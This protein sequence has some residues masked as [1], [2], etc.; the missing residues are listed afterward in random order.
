MPSITTQQ[1]VTVMVPLGGMLTV[2]GSGVGRI[3][4]LRQPNGSGDPYSPVAYTG[5][6]Q[7][8]GP[9]PE[10]RMYRIV[11]DLGPIN[12]NVPPVIV[13]AENRYEPT[14]T[15]SL[16]IGSTTINVPAGS[17]LTIAAYA[18]GAGVLYQLFNNAQPGPAIAYNGSELV[19]PATN[20]LR[21]YRVVCS[22]GM[23][24]M[25]TGWY[26]GSAVVPVPTLS[27]SSAVSQSEGNS[28]TTAFVWTLTLNRDGSTASFPFAWATSPGAVP[29]DVSDFGGSYPTGTGT[30]AP[31]ETIK[32]ITVLV[33]GDTSVE[34][35]ESFILTV[36]GAGLNTVTSSGTII[37]DDV[38]G[39]PAT[40]I[41]AT[42][43]LYE[44][45]TWRAWDAVS[46]GNPKTVGWYI[47]A[48]GQPCIVA[49]ANTWFDTDTPS[50][51]INSSFTGARYNADGSSTNVTLT[52]EPL[53]SHGMMKDPMLFDGNYLGVG[54][55]QGFAEVLAYEDTVTAGSPSNAARSVFS[56]SVNTDPG[57]TGLRKQAIEG[58]YVKAKNRTGVTTP[59]YNT[60]ETFSVLHVLPS[61]PNVGFF[62]PPYASTSKLPQYYASQRD[63]TALGAGFALPAGK[64]T[65]AANEAA[66]HFVRGV[67]PY[68]GQNGEKRRRY[69]IEP[70]ASNGYSRDYGQA[71]N[72][73]VTGLLSIGSVAPDTSLNR[74]LSFGMN[75]IGL[76]DRSGFV[77]EG[78]AG[79]SCSHKQFVQLLG[80]VFNGISGL[81]AKCLVFKGAV[82]IQPKIAT[83][84]EVGVLKDFPET[85]HDVFG[86]PYDAA[87]VDGFFWTDGDNS[88]E[89]DQ[90]YETTSGIACFGEFNNIGNMKN[91]PGGLDG[92]QVMALYYPATLGYY[93]FYRTVPEIYPNTVS[94]SR[95][96]A[97]YDATRSSWAAAKPAQKPN[98]ASHFDGVS[99]AALG[100]T[101]DYTAMGHSVE[102]VTGAE[103]EYSMDCVSYFGSV[104]GITGSVGSLVPGWRYY[105]RRRRQSATGWGK[106]SYNV[107]AGNQSITFRALGNVTQGSRTL[108]VT[109]VS[110]G[111][112]SIRVGDHV[113]MTGVTPGS[114]VTAFG[115]GTGGTGTYTLSMPAYQTAT[116]ATIR[117]GVMAGMV[118]PTGSPSGTVTW[119]SPATICRLQYGNNPQPLFAAI[120]DASQVALNEIVICA[121]GDMTGAVQAP[122]FQWNRD[123][124]AIS[125]DTGQSHVRTR[126]D[127][128]KTL[129]CTITSNG[130]SMTTAGIAFPESAY[131]A[132]S[133]TV[134]D[135]SDMLV[136]NAAL[137]GAAS[138]QQFTFAFCAPFTAGDGAFQTL[139]S[140]G[141]A[142]GTSGTD[143]IL[144]VDRTNTNAIQITARSGATVL[145]SGITAANAV[146]TVDVNPV[147]V[148][149]HDLA[150]ARYLVSVNGV[151]FP[152]G[153]I[154]GTFAA[155]PFN[156]VLRPWFYATLSS[157]LFATINHC[158]TFFDTKFIDI[159][160]SDPTTKA[161]NLA[162]FLPANIGNRGQN[163]FGSDPLVMLYGPAADIGTNFGTGGDYVK[164][165]VT[166]V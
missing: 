128:G 112:P 149:T 95:E 136:R 143:Y 121:M 160:H 54:L 137:V 20:A 113:A 79:Q 132:K 101:F 93:D 73:A 123:G 127:D 151:I 122:T 145:F 92:S 41:M 163:V 37:N 72:D 78:G 8:I 118:T 22:A 83:F 40:P 26:S 90:D 133:L 47:G 67:Q 152:L 34:L 102:T 46:D 84:A 29:V 1:V 15:K 164:P 24:N 16:G 68:F 56:T 70:S 94:T 66:G 124:V 91:W 39:T 25:T 166:D 82:T 7:V 59:A 111:S 30:F 97:Y 75:H 51:Q 52:N 50:V 62:A 155:V 36:T 69:M 28:G 126:A 161:A 87:D 142:A 86:R 88:S 165:S 131:P 109:S 44:G 23:M 3:I 49:D 31:G 74:M 38:E 107:R 64:P 18:G 144:R 115:T 5:V 13:T 114:Y 162:K 116:A 159:D 141:D 71:W 139:L 108:T 27:L 19:I 21:S 48:E 135:G 153:T 158:Y 117:S 76:Y 17:T 63:K 120:T 89:F 150:N 32:T 100:F 14:Y 53:W 61:V 98:S 129:T 60:F 57:F 148:V 65:L 130:Q 81:H 106:W 157:A 6:E 156:S 11:C 110:S 104:S 134:F 77:S 43:Y 2:S 10:L 146:R 125:G 138:S 35:N 105:T 58:S 147:V 96:D 42:T 80:H 140:F 45:I 119:R 9:V 99:A 154:S 4:R 85:N 103:T 55:P 33:I 12:Y